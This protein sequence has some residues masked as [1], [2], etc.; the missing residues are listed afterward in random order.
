MT[1][2]SMIRLNK[3]LADCGVA[4]RRACDELIAAGNVTVNGEVVLK[5][6]TK[7]SV[8]DQ[9]NLNGQ[10]VH[11]NQRKIYILLHKPVGYI[12]SV[13]DE[14][15]RKTVLDLVDVPERIFPVGRLDADSEGLLILTND[16]PL[17]HR[18]T[19]P[20]FKMSKTYRVFLDKKIDAETLRQLEEGIVLDDGHTLPCRANFLGKSRTAVELVLCEGRKRQ[21]RRMFAALGFNVRRLSR[22]Q[23]GPLKI[24]RLKRG[25]WRFLRKEE[26]N[27]LEHMVGLTI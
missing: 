4:S 6:G 9:I 12:T 27:R 20:R 17:A 10:P 19:H 3:Y 7:V 25:E 1:N 24:R 11:P 13:S 2:R 16:G 15:G 18:L 8:K 14:R 23:F 21:I 22:T 5:L 26:V